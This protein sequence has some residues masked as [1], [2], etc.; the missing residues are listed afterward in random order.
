V[1]GPQSYT[2]SNLK[3]QSH[4]QQGEHPRYSSKSDEAQK[5]FVGPHFWLTKHYLIRVTESGVLQYI[6]CYRQYNNLLK[7]E[8]F[9]YV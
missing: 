6:S 9:I 8:F 2:T 1:V 5:V 7:N 3:Q 4:I